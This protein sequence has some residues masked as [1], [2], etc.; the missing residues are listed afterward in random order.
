MRSTVPIEHRLDG[1]TA[2]R[3]Y[4]LIGLHEALRMS[5]GDIGAMLDHT[6][7]RY[8]GWGRDPIAIPCRYRIDAAADRLDRRL[9]YRLGDDYA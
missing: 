4:L 8:L 9:G 5:G 1:L 2:H 3:Y 6:A 7:A